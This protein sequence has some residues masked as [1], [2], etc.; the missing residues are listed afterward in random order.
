[1]YLSCLASINENIDT[2]KTQVSTQPIKERASESSTIDFG[3]TINLPPCDTDIFYGD[4]TAWPTFRDMFTA[5]YIHNPKISN[6]EKLFH[7]TQMTR[8]EA[9]EA[10]KNTPLTNDG[11]ILAWKN[12]VE[13]YENKRMQINTQLKTLFNLPDVTQETG[14]AIKA[15]QRTVNNVLTNLTH[16]EIDTKSWDPILIYLCSSKLPKQTLEAFESTLEDITSIPTWSN[17]D[18]FLTHKQ[19]TLESVANF[20]ASVTKLHSSHLGSVKKTDGNKYYTFH[21]NVS[22][23]LLAGPSNYQNRYTSSQPHPEAES[24][25]LCN[26]HHPIRECPK[27]LEMNVE[28]RISTIKRHGY[29]NNCLAISHSY[30]NCSSKN[31]CRKCHKRHNTLIHREYSPRPESTPNPEA[32][33]STSDIAISAP[34]PTHNTIQPK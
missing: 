20:K 13:Q 2:R 19:N 14:C 21:A 15:L 28:T 27:F 6:V 7:L 4:Y 16:L 31:T 3:P 1:M 29:C 30:K 33:S 17:F 24:C 22:E 32:T 8:G 11:F 10:I 9:R 23:N 34:I 25:K 12:L 18:N 5:L 26:K